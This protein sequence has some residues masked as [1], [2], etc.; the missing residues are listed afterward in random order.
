VRAKHTRSYSDRSG[1]KGAT[2]P[3]VA[4]V[5]TGAPA[6]DGKTPGGKSGGRVKVARVLDVLEDCHRALELEDPTEA[7]R[8]L[9]EF[10]EWLRCGRFEEGGEAT[11][12]KRRGCK[13]RKVKQL[14]P[15]RV[16]PR[17][18]RL[19]RLDGWARGAGFDGYDAYMRSEHWLGLRRRYVA[20][21]PDCRCVVCG[22][23]RFQLHHLRYDRLGREELRDLVPL[24]PKCHDKVHRAHRANKIPLQDFEAAAQAAFGWGPAQTRRA[25]DR[26]DALVG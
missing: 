26:Y 15:A 12:K 19:A 10:G 1:A 17:P 24:C 3:T 5:G 14:A 2:H 6:D 8:V 22:S 13:A 9:E 21:W 16:V 23:I 11:M 20:S 25:L 18:A 4:T 7:R